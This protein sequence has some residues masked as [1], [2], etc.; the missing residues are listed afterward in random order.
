ML[1]NTFLHIPGIGG[2]TE[3]RFWESGVHSWQDFTKDC[4][5]RLSP[6]K[7]ETISRYIQESQQHIKSGKPEYFSDLLPANQ[8]WR[9]F[10]EFRDSTVY[11]DIETTGLDRYYDSI[12]TIALYDGEAIFYYVNGRN[13][14]DFLDVINSYKVIVSYNGK[15]FDIPFIES[16]FGIKLNHAQID[17]RYI[18]ASL[19]YKGGLKSCE[20]QLGIDRGDLKDID[21]YFAVLLWN[22]YQEHGN[23]KALESML[24]YNI[25]DTV[26]LETLM[27]EAYN[28][29]IRETPFYQKQLKDS[30]LPKNPFRADMKTVERIKREIFSAPGMLYY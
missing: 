15:S 28:M 26:N 11:L 22:D 5:I 3:K 30:V 24:A 19:G 9:L 29:K 27:I 13:L 10:P 1:K 8:Q 2:V 16:S 17:L 6:Y 21:G 23:E 14:N 7:Q 20:V 25:Q 12:T 4:P 18:L